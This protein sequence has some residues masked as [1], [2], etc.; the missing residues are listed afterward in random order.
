MPSSE[1]RS[2]L[3][4]TVTILIIIFII[5]I[6]FITLFLPAIGT[7]PAFTNKL[8]DDFTIGKIIKDFE[9][10][11]TSISD[12]HHRGGINTNKHAVLVIAWVGGP[13]FVAA[14]IRAR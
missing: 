11:V 7:R 3:I 5:F 1:G 4:F 10:V 6:I 9:A 12:S 2:S 14:P 8:L 13:V